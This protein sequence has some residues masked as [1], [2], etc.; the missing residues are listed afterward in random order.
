MELDFVAKAFA[1]L[2]VVNCPDNRADDYHLN[3]AAD[4][5]VNDQFPGK[6]LDRVDGQTHAD[7]RDL[8]QNSQPDSRHYAATG[9]AARINRHES[10]NQKRLAKNDKVKQ[11]HHFTLRPPEIR[12]F[13]VNVFEKNALKQPAPRKNENVRGGECEDESLHELLYF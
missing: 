11:A 4:A 3:E 10:K 5:P 8:Q 2:W 6:R 1:Q 12:R 13:R 7:C 9:E